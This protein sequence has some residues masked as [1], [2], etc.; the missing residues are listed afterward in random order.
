[1]AL[2]IGLLLPILPVTLR[3]YV[4]GHEPVLIAYQG[5]VNL[6]IGNNPDADGLTMQM[7]EIVLDPTVAWSEFVG[8][9][10]SIARAQSGL[11]LTTSEI[12]GYWTDKALDYMRSNPGATLW[13]WVKKTY[14]MLNGFEAGDQT[15]IYDF[16][17]YSSLL[18][19]L[20]WSG[21]LFFPVT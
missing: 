8:T 5:G 15:D 13:R 9:T 11:P 6:Y 17:R 4:V 7:P 3:N 18:G 1:M 10:D 2:L 12:S 21:P 20:I 16:T 14:Y 19:I